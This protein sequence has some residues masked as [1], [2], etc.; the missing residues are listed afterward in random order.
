[1]FFEDGLAELVSLAEGNGPKRSGSFESEAEPADSAENV[2][3]SDF[4]AHSNPSP[5]AAQRLRICRSLFLVPKRVPDCCFG[6]VDHCCHL[7]GGH[8]APEVELAYE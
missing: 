8:A 1:V 6:R 4:I 7:F 5:A 2:E 3:N